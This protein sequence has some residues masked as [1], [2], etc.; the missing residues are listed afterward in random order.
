LL[1]LL[2]G[3]LCGCSGQPGPDEKNSPQQLAQSAQAAYAVF[4]EYVEVPVDVKPA[5]PPYKVE[6][7]L[8][9]ITNK[10]MF[11]LS[12]AARELLVKNGFVVVPNQYEK[13]FFSLYER[14]HY[15][16]LPLFITT[17]SV[18]HN[19]HLFFNHLLRVVETEKL[20]GELMKLNQGML[21]QA[22][23]QYEDLKGTE[24]ENAAKRNVGFFAVAGKLMDPEL[25]VPSM[26]KDVVE[27]ELALIENHRG[28]AVSPLMNA[29]GSNDSDIAFQEDYS[30]YIP[31]GH[32]ERT[33][34]LQ[35]YFKAMM[36]YGRMTFRLKND[37]ETRSA[38][39]M[40]LAL[41][42]G[43]NMVSWEKIYATT[44]FFVG[45]SDDLSCFQYKE[46]IDR[47]YGANASL[48]T[49][50]SNPGKWQD[51]L[52]AAAELA[53][54]AINSMPIFDET[55]Q[56]DR[57]AEIKGFR[58]M[59]Q[60][61]TIDASIFQRLIY[62]EVKENSQDQR[63]MLPKGLD[64]P[65]AMGSAEAY[66]I[67][68]S[69]GETA[70]Q[71]YPENMAKMR[72]YIAGLGKEIWTQNLYWSWLYTLMPLVQEKPEGYPSFMRNSAWARKELNTSGQLDG[73]KA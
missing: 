26:V 50:V 44:S 11:E 52:A 6:P 40:T 66:S 16:P 4:A 34:L 9:N 46:L 1:L 67:L 59:G 33:E 19:Y 64:I 3:T 68:E 30:Q 61:S 37:D 73:V 24:W 10:D 69:M 25:P 35:N 18:L 45:K 31:R 36:W 56:P 57:E 14:N 43:D 28:I 53:P 48:K 39:L 41:D 55:I 13:E 54:P 20:A 15:E 58:F 70:Y 12:P 23:N 5:V 7:D 51:F 62:R 29:F 72:T 60:R 49:V 42:Q 65:A 38:V 47:I 71:G 27:K 8:A 21:S 17:D 22:Q 63:R 32:Y 2:L